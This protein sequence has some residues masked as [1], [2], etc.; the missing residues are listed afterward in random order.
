MRI[1]MLGE[2]WNLSRG[3]ND[4]VFC[5]SHT[6]MLHLSR[7]LRSSIYYYLIAMLGEVSDISPVLML[8]SSVGVI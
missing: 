2:G 1:L 4:V 6:V 3:I 5:R 8:W 7:G